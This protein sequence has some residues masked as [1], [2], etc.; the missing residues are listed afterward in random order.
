MVIAKNAW[1]CLKKPSL[2]CGA[3]LKLLNCQIHP[4]CCS[5][6]SQSQEATCR[7]DLTRL[8]KFPSADV[9]KNGRHCPALCRRIHGRR[10]EAFSIKILLEKGN[11][12]T[13]ARFVRLWTAFLRRSIVEFGG[14]YHPFLKVG[15]IWS[16]RWRTWKGKVNIQ[17]V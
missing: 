9:I 11:Q 7:A 8:K 1:S 14:P 13:N 5:K 16:S 17:T 2:A 10:E 4:G 12:G 3:N 6:I 15:T